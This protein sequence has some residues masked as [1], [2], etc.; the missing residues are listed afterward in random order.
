MMQ[1]FR[2]YRQIQRHIVS[3]ISRHCILSLAGRQDS[4]DTIVVEHTSHELPGN[5]PKQGASSF[6]SSLT[7]H[8]NLE[9]PGKRLAQE[10]PA[11]GCSSA[12]NSSPKPVHTGPSSVRTRHLSDVSLEEEQGDNTEEDGL[13]VETGRVM[14]GISICRWTTRGDG[15][16]G[17]DKMLVV[18]FEGKSDALNPQTWPLRKRAL[19][20]CQVTLIAW[21][22][23]FASSVDSQVLLQA[24]AEFGI[25]P[26]VESLATGLFLIAFGTG[27]LIAG[28]CS[29]EF[30]RNP[31]YITSLTLFMLFVMASGLAP[32][33]GPQIAFRFLAGFF[34]STPLVCAGGTLTDLFTPKERVV[35]FP[36]FA[37]AAFCGPVLGPVVGGFIAQSPE[38]SWRWTDWITLCATGALLILITLLLP[39]TYAPA[40]LKYKAQLLRQAT[41]DTRYVAA[42]ETRDVPFG[43][44]LLRALYRPLGLVAR[45][46]ILGLLSAYLAAVH[47]VLFGFLVGFEYVFGARYDLPEDLTDLAFLGIATGVLASAALV[48]L[49]HHVHRRAAA[50]AAAGGS[51]TRTTPTPE[52]RLWW[53]M[54]GAPMMPASLF[55]MGWTSS[56]EIALWAP[57]AATVMFGFS[58]ICLFIGCCQYLIDTYEVYAASALAS[59]TFI[60]YRKCCPL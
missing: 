25:S 38:V 45:E 27:S 15:E 4:S 22:V 19:A 11:P 49:M 55:W 52:I 10:K 5:P 46:P 34:G 17:D 31:V 37:A 26:I 58:F 57:L 12:S 1:S 44:R 41:G 50:R 32:S 2:Q 59:A 40:L 23:S 56:R 3:Q 47:V 39:E 14:A 21:T 30:G 51:A 13:G 48:P 20:M 6:D 29:E 8:T 33:I 9:D 18:G 24:A 28:P 16:K 54:V 42:A 53:A 36:L 35:V 7:P 60:R 43:R